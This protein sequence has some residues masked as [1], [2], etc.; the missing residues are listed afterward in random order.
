MLFTVLKSNGLFQPIRLGFLF[1]RRY[2]IYPNFAEGFGLQ[3]SFFL[4]SRKYVFWHFFIPAISR[5]IPP[6]HP[7]PAASAI[8]AIF[9]HC[10]PFP[11]ILSHFQPFSAI[12]SH[13]Q[14]FQP[15]PAIIPSF[16]H[17]INQSSQY[18]IIPSSP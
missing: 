14:P 16:H 3:P 18:S 12:F 10:Q 1:P 4:L 2:G 11:A 13:V 17:H 5:Y 6:F 15:F 7:F 8:L 9:S